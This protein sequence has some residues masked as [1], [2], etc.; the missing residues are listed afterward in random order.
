[1]QERKINFTRS[2]DTSPIVLDAKQN[3]KLLESVDKLIQVSLY[4][5]ELVADGRL[6]VQTS[7]TVN[8]LFE[9]YTIDIHK[10]LDYSGQLKADVDARYKEIRSL[11]EENRALRTQL[12]ERV[13]PDDVRERFKIMKADL[14]EWWTDNGCG[15]LPKVWLEEHQLRVQVSFNI[16][17]VS[18]EKEEVVAILE[19]QG[20]II[21]KSNSDYEI[22]DCD[23]NRQ[24][25]HDLVQKTFP[26][27]TVWEIKSWGGNRF[28]MRDAEFMINNLDDLDK[29]HKV[30]TQQP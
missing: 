20:V 15:Y 30:N 21:N 5:K 1:M 4:L 2:E 28:A 11:N 18:R 13:H 8:G 10:I 25:F 22:I 23:S 17:G 19:K 26:S 27:G 3:K 12:G 16:S 6:T 24:W 7:N 29:I 9:A 14:R